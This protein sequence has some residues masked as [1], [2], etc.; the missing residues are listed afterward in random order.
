LGSYIL[1]NST[2]Y[3]TAVPGILSS[4]KFFV[5]LTNNGNFYVLLLQYF[6][7][8]SSSII[9]LTFQVIQG[10]AK[11]THVFEMGSTSERYV[12]MLRNF[13]RPQLRSL[14]VNMEEMWFQQY[15]ATAHTARASMTVV[16][17]M[18]PQHSLAFRRC[19]LAPTLTRFI[20]LRFISLGLPQIKSLRSKTSYSQ[21]SESF[22][23]QRNCNCATRNVS[24]CDAEL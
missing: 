10:G 20:C 21:R 8:S 14:R 18:F 24:K 6:N 16:R 23:S 17:Q 13:L 12:E 1:F 15:G 2:V 9:P 7:S 5:C 3:Y 19:P 4:L 11:R 22:H